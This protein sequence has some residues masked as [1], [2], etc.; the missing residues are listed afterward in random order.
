M[1]S[2][3]VQ[4]IANNAY[5]YISWHQKPHDTITAKEALEIELQEHG[6]PLTSEEEQ[7][8]LHILNQLLQQQQP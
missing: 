5:E 8:A 7:K 3:L 4:N 2:K 1:N 6:E